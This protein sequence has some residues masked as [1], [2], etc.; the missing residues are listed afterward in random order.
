MMNSPGLALILIWAAVFGAAVLLLRVTWSG[1]A[2]RVLWSCGA[3]A[4][5][6]RKLLRGRTER[7]PGLF[8]KF[9]QEGLAA[10][11]PK[12]I[13]LGDSAQPDADLREVTRLLIQGTDEAVISKWIQWRGDARA[14]RAEAAERCFTLLANASHSAVVIA[15][16]IVSVRMGAIPSAAAIAGLLASVL[17]F[18]ILGVIIRGKI[19]TLT[20]DGQKAQRQL[21]LWE[22]GFRA[23]LSPQQFREFLKGEFAA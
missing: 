21:E 3:E 13:E 5:A 9:R 16:L 23:G 7:M 1:V 19:Q 15:V 12:K 14:G 18:F 8:E 10:L 11:D 17:A 4:R 20:L 6:L 22:L 2:V